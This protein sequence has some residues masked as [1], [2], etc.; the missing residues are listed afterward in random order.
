MPAPRS[1]R[2]L[3]PLLLLL[4]SPRAAK[5][6]RWVAV[7]V[8]SSHTCALDSRGR[9]FCWGIN[10][11]GELGAHTPETCAP[12]HHGG[13]RSCYASPSREPV[14]VAGG[15]RF[16]SIS[17]GS[18]VSCGLDGRG[19]AWC[20]GQDVGTARGGCARGEVCAF[21]PQ[22]FAPEMAFRFLRVAEDAVCGI[23]R[24]GAGHCWRPVHGRPGRA[25]TEVAPGERLAWV[26][27]YGDWM[28]RDE[29]LI[30]AAT[31]DGRALC[32]GMNDLAQL[33][34]GDTVPRT[35]AVRVAS[36]A[37]FTRVHPWGWSACGLTAEG[38]AECWGAAE[39]RPSWPGGAPSNPA[40]FACGTSAWCSGPRAAAP[41][42]RFAALTFVDDRFCGLAAGEVHCWGIE[43]VPVRAAEGLR[44]TALEGG[45]THACGL[46]RDGAIWC[47]G[48]DV[49]E[50]LTQ[51]V[52]VP[53]PPR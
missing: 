30:C 47:W 19:R 38:A 35:G 3:I 18:N 32:Q 17:A 16:R 37:R 40:F 5:A 2:I 28:A 41:G 15:T 24:Q 8:G 13:E 9:A 21:A 12:A 45:E 46:T 33:G 51:P 22:P 42:L 10:H 25:M 23:T 36:A 29:H 48:Q 14:A 44:F 4:L 31:V 50:D 1:V 43:G 27:H 39:P 6:Q 53:D 20:W 11:Y 7:D 26:D 49:D 52:R 34:A